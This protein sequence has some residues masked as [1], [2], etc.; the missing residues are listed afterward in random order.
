[1]EIKPVY[2]DLKVG[3]KT[4]KFRKWKVKDREQ[5]RELSQT[6][7]E[8]ELNLKMIEIFV[9][10][11]LDKEYDL[12]PDELEFIFAKIREASI[13]PNI[14]FKRICPNCQTEIEENL[15][16]D[17]IYKVSFD[18]IDKTIEIDDLTIKLSNIKNIEYYN[19]KMKESKNIKFT[20]FILHIESINDEPLDY[21]EIYKLLYELDTQTVDTIFEYYDRIR[22]K[23]DKTVEFTCKECNFKEKYYFDELPDFFENNWLLK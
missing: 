21:D 4:I 2:F 15:K 19:K 10:N 7:E 12:N 16:I 22:F 11:C 13:S 5:F 23:I 6:L 17:D 20:D 18:E 9:Y 8:S 1:M 14:K 3:N